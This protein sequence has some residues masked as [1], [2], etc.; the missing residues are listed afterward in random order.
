MSL[1]A[2]RLR[3]L[4]QFQERSVTTNPHEQEV[5]SWADA[6]QEF[7]EVQRQSEQVCRFTIRYRDVS[8]KKWPADY[9]IL[10]FDSI[11]TI[12]S[13]VPDIPRTMLIIDSDFSS[14]VEA[15]H[16]QSTEREH[17]DGVPLVRP[18]EE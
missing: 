15:T 6:F 3:D 4:I 11:W 14:L 17:I 12:T 5:I 1:N 18:P 8:P 7:S 2:G 16:L 10:F 13:A 9:R